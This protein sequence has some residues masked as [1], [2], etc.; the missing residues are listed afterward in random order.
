[1]P[2]KIMINAIS[3]VLAMGLA[4]TTAQAAANPEPSQD[5]SQM[6]GNLNGMEKCYGI[7]K[8]GQNDCGSAMHSCAGEAKIDRDKQSW[9]IVPTGV[10]HKIIGGSTKAPDKAS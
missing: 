5:M 2:T 1:M 3:A 4:G 8:K 10:C 6:M 7:A 9:M